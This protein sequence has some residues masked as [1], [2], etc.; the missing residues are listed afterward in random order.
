MKS[1]C[2]LSQVTQLV[3]KS[4]AF[5]YTFAM[6]FLDLL[7]PKYCVGCKK[8]GGY[9]CPDCFVKVRFAEGGFCTICQKAAI[10]GLTH[11]ICQKQNTIDGVFSSLLYKGIVKKLVYQFKYKP[12]LT[13]LQDTLTEFFYEGLI[14]KESFHTAL[15]TRSIFVPIPLHPSKLKKRGYNQSML[16]AKGLSHS[17]SIP[18]SDCLTRVVNT[19]TQVGLSQKERIVNITGAFAVRKEVD[20]I[21]SSVF[22]VDDVV[23]TGATLREA[24]RVLKKAGVKNVWGITLAHG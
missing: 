5:R 15:V 3:V 2:V 22:L 18:I 4:S 1:S 11:P 17:L 8:I 12:Y 9:I 23:T 20:L 10:G 16:L 14:Q 21:G 7:F 19:K 24:A 6:S 13:N